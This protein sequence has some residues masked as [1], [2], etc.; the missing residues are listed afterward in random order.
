MR[1]C[2]TARVVLT[3]TCC[4]EQAERLLRVGERSVEPLPRLRGSSVV[5]EERAPGGFE[6]CTARGSRASSAS[7]IRAAASC[8]AAPR[9]S[10]RGE[11]RRSGRC[12]QTSRSASAG[13][14]K[15]AVSGQSARRRLDAVVEHAR[16]V[17]QLELDPPSPRRVSSH[18][19][20]CV[21][22]ARAVTAA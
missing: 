8:C 11:R 15:R 10:D 14:S 5:G 1:W 7:T 12:Q 20:S 4:A 2:S 19:R 6:R 22:P 16:L 9:P 13:C 18:L 21:R 3:A 17:G